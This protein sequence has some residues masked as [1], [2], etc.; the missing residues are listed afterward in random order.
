MT[1]KKTLNVIGFGSVGQAAYKMF[2]VVVDKGLLPEVERIVYHAPEI[3]E[4]REDGIFTFIPCAPVE[5]HTLAPLLDSM[6]LKEG[7]V[8]I[9]LACRIDS[10]TIWREVKTRGCHFLNTGFDVW[11]DLELDLALI[12]A[13]QK[14]AFFGKG[15]TS[16]FSFGC[17]PGIASHFVRHGLYIATGIADAR[18]AA[19][20]FGLR[21]VSF[22]ERD[23]QYAA[24][25]TAGEAK[26][27]ALQL[28]ELWNTWS[29]G[30]YL[31]ETAEST[32]LF[33]G[34]SE[35]AAKMSS[36]GPAVIAWIPSGPNV[37]FLAPHDETFTIQQWFDK[38]IPA[39][40][41]YEAPPAARAYLKGGRRQHSSV[42][43]CHLLTP[44]EY[45]VESTG[46]DHLGALL[47][48]DKPEVAPFW[49]G[50]KM[51]VADAAVIDP[52][53]SVGPTPFQVTGG[54]WCALQFVLRHP[55]EGDLFPEDLPTQF[56]MEN[57]FPW[58][59][60][61][62][63]R[64]APEALE[65]PGLFIPERHVADDLIKFGE[66]DASR[67]AKGASKVHGD[68]TVATVDMPTTS[69]IA[70]LAFEPIDI[71]Q[72]VLAHTTPS[73]FNHSCDANAYVDRNRAVRLLRPVAAGEEITL[74]YSLL[75]PSA[76]GPAA[77]EGECHCG[78]ANCRKTIGNAASV[79]AEQ[80]KKIVKTTAILHDAALARVAENRV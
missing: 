68:G 3:K 80:L 33:A 38:Q 12:E 71:L 45:D 73:C 39:A 19:R 2:K 29:P 1:Q 74:D 10:A 69:A 79:P 21:A 55:T 41:V 14:D 25:G 22:N 17:N 30:N 13:L 59:G 75:V 40:F 34:C 32:V 66:A 51:D 36:A 8:V 4:R 67:I 24:P 15:K 9:E 11:A 16:V 77:L 46:Y 35:E 43:K 37:G 52:S 61:L 6:N 44:A 26:L 42:A 78:S 47:F 70:Q 27:N 65:V 48:S 31:V 57:A 60:R 20:A 5:R 64:P 63:A 72:V 18:E 62:E 56:V 7:D 49:C 58:A 50:I 23:T 54:L 53:G 76:T 28:D